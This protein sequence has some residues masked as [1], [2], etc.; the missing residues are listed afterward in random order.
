[1]I[2]IEILG[3]SD[4]ST[5]EQLQ[6]ITRDLLDLCRKAMDDDGYIAFPIDRMQ[7]DL[8]SEI[9]VVVY[10]PEPSFSFTTIFGQGVGLILE[11]HF[12]A[13]TLIN[14]Q[15]VEAKTVREFTKKS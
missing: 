4:D 10:F 7:M 5:E 13:G 2:V 12:P 9:A 8:G 6:A 1:M 11:R 14:V 15:I 3:T